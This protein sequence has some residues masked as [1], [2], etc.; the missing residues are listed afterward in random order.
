MRI[1][2]IVQLDHR[3][4]EESEVAT[5]LPQWSPGLVATH[6]L[7]SCNGVTVIDGK[8]RMP[9]FWPNGNRRRADS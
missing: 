3:R 1:H 7:N 2:R 4:Y 6:T 9:K 8:R 5:I